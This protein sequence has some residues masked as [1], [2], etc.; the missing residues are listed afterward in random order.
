VSIS[1]LA[2]IN[3]DQFRGLLNFEFIN[4]S[5]NIQLLNSIQYFLDRHFQEFMDARKL[6]IPKIKF[7]SEEIIEMLK[8]FN[9]KTK[10]EEVKEHQIDLA[11][12]LNQINQEETDIPKFI[13][14]MS[15]T[16]L[17]STFEDF[18]AKC[19]RHFFQLN[20]KALLSSRNK[21]KGEQE[22]I[23]TYN[24]ILQCDNQNEIIE[25]LIQKELDII[26]RKDIDE[27]IQD[28]QNLLKT[29][30]DDA[31]DFLAFK[32]I[33]Y[34]RN[35]IIHH[36]GYTNPTYNRKNNLAKKTLEELVTD[37]D[38]LQKSFKRMIAYAEKIK[39]IYLEKIPTN[40]PN[41]TFSG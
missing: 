11:I 15:L 39:T 26:M 6:T 31:N 16:Y 34:R 18:F 41:S 1:P 7:N 24:D 5:R 10:P 23:V 32:E 9:P 13:R 3:S 4:L 19:L 35:S 8:W 33:F 17:V 37:Y 27:I 28:F 2:I 30:I 25:S 21:A 38:Y 40:Q 36:Q 22:K 12:K 20:P 14:N 29:N